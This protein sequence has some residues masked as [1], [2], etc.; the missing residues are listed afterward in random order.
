[1]KTP[2]IKIPT[3]ITPET[4]WSYYGSKSKIIGLYPPPKYGKIIEPFAG[5]ARYSLKWFDRDVTI[6]DKYAVITDLWKWLQQCSKKDILNL[7]DMKKGDDLREIDLPKEAKMLIG[8][9]INQGSS[10]PKNIASGFNGWEIDK[11]RISDNLWKIKHWNII[12][13]SYEDL[14]NESATW[15]IDPPYQFGG[16]WYVESTKNIDYKKL[17]EWCKSRNGQIIVCENTK[18]DWMDFKPMV[19]MQGSLYKTTEA[20]WSNLPTNYDNVQLKMF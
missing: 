18:A 19:D 12:N 10:S 9:S 15:F 2:Q 8:F 1:M 3:K 20:I 14:E 7:P 17:G 6:V 4:M 5:T 13:G 11:K 16:E